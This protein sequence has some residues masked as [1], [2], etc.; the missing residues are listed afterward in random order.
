M[1]AGCYCSGVKQ[2]FL[3]TYPRHPVLS[4]CS[5]CAYTF[6]ASSI[7]KLGAGSN[8]IIRRLPAGF[9]FHAQEN[10]SMRRLHIF[11]AVLRSY[12][13]YTQASSLLRRFN[14]LRAEQSF[15]SSHA[16]LRSY[17]Q[18]L[19]GHRCSGYLTSS[20]PPPHPSCAVL[21]SYAQGSYGM[22]PRRSPCIHLRRP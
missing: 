11:H 10:L 7:E 3:L 6:S 15:G 8:R 9:R 16:V 5:E 21:R 2:A 14:G 13:Q 1:T 17:A 18:C 4:P 22:M 12:A 19:A 20:P